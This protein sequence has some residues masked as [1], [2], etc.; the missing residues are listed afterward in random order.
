[1]PSSRGAVL[2]PRQGSQGVEEN[3]ERIRAETAQLAGTQ[4]MNR[5]SWGSGFPR[6]TVILLT[7]ALPQAIVD[8]LIDAGSRLP[9]IVNENQCIMTSRESINHATVTLVATPK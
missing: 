1:M 3:A 5:W 9:R 4:D 2:S 6:N 8:C 7:A